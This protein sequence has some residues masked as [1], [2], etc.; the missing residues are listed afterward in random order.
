MSNKLIE[1]S[2]K[3]LIK[4]WRL[5]FFDALNVMFEPVPDSIGLNTNKKSGDDR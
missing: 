5:F 4:S 3:S 2:L 1:E